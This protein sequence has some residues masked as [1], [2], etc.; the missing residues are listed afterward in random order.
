MHESQEYGY[1]MLGDTYAVTPQDIYRVT[2]VHTNRVTK[3][4]TELVTKGVLRKDEKGYYSKRMVEDEKLRC[5]RR[6]AG[7]LG[8][9]PDLVKRTG[10]QNS[11]PSSSS[12]SSSA[13]KK[14]IYIDFNVFWEKYDKKVRE[15]KCRKLWE[16]LTDEE[17]E[18]AM[19]KISEFKRQ[20][21]EKRF[22]PNPEKYLSEK[23]WK[24]EFTTS[25]A[26][27]KISYRSGIPMT[28]KQV[29]EYY[30][31]YGHWPNQNPE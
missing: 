21:S 10:K 27:K 29:Q 14:D 26:E 9:N 17:R 1:L 2:G 6:E 11:T 19:V 7:K 28:Q 4:V 8:G 13:L 30:D 23:R 31:K 20:F 15:E 24:D 5:I 16:N 12:S 18:L 22:I 25:Q 3:V